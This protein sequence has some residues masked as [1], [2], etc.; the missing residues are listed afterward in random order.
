[1]DRVHEWYQSFHLTLT[2][3]ENEDAFYNIKTLELGQH[4]KSL[5]VASMFIHQNQHLGYRSSNEPVQQ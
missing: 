5:K 4:C 3:K 1:M 2:K